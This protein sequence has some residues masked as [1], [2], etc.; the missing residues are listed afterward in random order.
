METNPREGYSRFLL[1][2]YIIAACT[3][4]FYSQ[5]TS[6]QLALLISLSFSLRNSRSFTSSQLSQFISV[7]VQ[8]FSFSLSCVLDIK[9]TKLKSHFLNE[10]HLQTVLSFSACV[11]ECI[12][13]IKNVLLTT[14]PS[15]LTSSSDKATNTLKI[16][17]T[18][19]PLNLSN[20]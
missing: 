15:Y 10:R 8:S 3:L 9:Y 18:C 2:V 16:K 11:C 19:F 17:N 4:N 6:S 5:F 14:P 20:I 7:C 1:A 13:H 12:N